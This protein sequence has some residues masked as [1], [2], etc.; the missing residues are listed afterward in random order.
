[1]TPRSKVITK[2]PVS[3]GKRL[4]PD[5]CE[6]ARTYA[7]RSDGVVV[8][9]RHFTADGWDRCERGGAPVCPEETT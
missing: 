2:R 1:M 7:R 4:C 9:E 5:C 8:F 3:H 6:E